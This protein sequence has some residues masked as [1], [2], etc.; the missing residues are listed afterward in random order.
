MSS[1]K[2]FLRVGF[3]G[4]KDVWDRKNDDDYEIRHFQEATE[5]KSITDTLEELKK[6]IGGLILF[7]IFSL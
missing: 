3:I 6:K 2:I 1:E 5:K 7:L 4:Y